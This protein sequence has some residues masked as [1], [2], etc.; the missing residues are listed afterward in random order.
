MFSTLSKTYFNSV[1]TFILLSANAF[2]LDQSTNLLF[3]KE[4]IPTEC[5]VLTLSQTSP[6]FYVSAVQVF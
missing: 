3:H 4:L 2:D 1:V 5:G 6:G